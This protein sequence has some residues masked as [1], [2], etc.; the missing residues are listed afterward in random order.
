MMLSGFAGREALHIAAYSHLIETLGMLNQHIQSLQT[1]KRCR[2]N[3][4][5]FLTYHQRMA[6]KNHGDSHRVF[7]ALQKVCSCFHHS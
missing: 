6:Q 5:M 7:S 3:M 4:I 1:M 2:I